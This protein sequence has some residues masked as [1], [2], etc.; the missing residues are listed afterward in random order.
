MTAVIYSH[1]HVDHSHVDHFGGVKGI[2][3]QG[4]VDAGRVEVV[5]PA[6]LVEHAVPVDT[7][8]GE[9]EVVLAS[10]HWP[11]W[12]AQRIIDF[13]CIQRDLYAYLHY[14]ARLWQHP[15]GCSIVTPEREKRALCTSACR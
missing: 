2:T 14:R 5:A 7:F 4:E 9:A 12:G 11:I 8:G 1:S 13:L 15:P 6:G 3:T 10:H